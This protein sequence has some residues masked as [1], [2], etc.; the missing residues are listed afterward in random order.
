[1]QLYSAS[2]QWATRPADERFQTLED[3][4]AATLAYAQAAATKTVPWSELRVEASGEDLYLTRG[5]TP[6]RLT[7]FAFKQL[8]ARAGAPPSYVSTLPATLAA[9]NLNYGLKNR[10]GAATE[11]QLLFHQ[12]GSLVLRA[13]TSDKYERVWNHEVIARLIDTASRNSLVPAKQTFSWDGTPVPADA[14]AALYAS[15]HD[16]FAFLMSTARDLQ[17]P[18]GGLMRRGIIVTNS[19]V[20][21]RS[22]GIMGFAF[23]DVCRNHIIWGAEQIAEVRIAHVG[24]IHRKWFDAQVRVRQYLDGAAS[25]DSARYAEWTKRIAGTKDEVLDAVFGKRIL[26]RSK[27]ADAYEAVVVEQDGDPM[28]QWG[29]AQGITRLSQGPFA[30]ERHEMDRAAGRLLAVSF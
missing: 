2:N 25:L 19:E 28:T 14:P 4:H 15:D 20:G 29:L 9:Q 6:A 3:M 22:L 18:T 5:A 11:A 13:A 17:T 16:M 24:E 21:D 26:S 8:S 12:N 7:N 10:V 1:M 23:V 27:L 30:D